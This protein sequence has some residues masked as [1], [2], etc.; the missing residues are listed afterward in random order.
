MQGTSRINPFINLYEHTLLL[1]SLRSFA[2]DFDSL[3]W[4]FSVETFGVSVGDLGF[5]S[6]D[7]VV[8]SV[9]NSTLVLNLSSIIVFASF[10]G[11]SLV[12]SRRGI[13]SSGLGGSCFS[14][15]FLYQRQTVGGVCM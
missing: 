7:C 9:P 11:E 1:P 5:V 3:F 10:V 14:D 6:V 8:F 13:C 2:F 4:V 12:I 15:F